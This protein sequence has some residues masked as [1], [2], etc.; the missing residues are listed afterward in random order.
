M[1]RRPRVGIVLTPPPPTRPGVRPGEYLHA[2]GVCV[3]LALPCLPLVAV[4]LACAFLLLV[5]AL[6][7]LHTDPHILNASIFYGIVYGAHA[8]TAVAP[9]CNFKGPLMSRHGL[10]LR[11]FAFCSCCVQYGSWCHSNPAMPEAD[12]W[13]A[14]QPSSRR[15][16]CGTV[17]DRRALGGIGGQAR[18]SPCMCS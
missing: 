10:V 14:I 4:G 6:E 15:V 7:A 13:G 18:S 12:C 8:R 3:A 9:L 16:R 2:V 5:A 1:F 17:T 11:N